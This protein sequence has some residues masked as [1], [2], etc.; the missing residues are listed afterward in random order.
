MNIITK[1]DNEN[2]ILGRGMSIADNRLKDVQNNIQ[3][4]NHENLMLR[5]EI[6]RL[7]SAM[8]PAAE[9]VKK[10]ESTINQMRIYIEN[11][12]SGNDSSSSSSSGDGFGGG[13]GGG[14]DGPPPDVF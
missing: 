10:L 1:K 4:I 12:V 14:F 8:Q 7:R 3:L 13:F 9:Y 5:Q 6:D 2:K 11:K